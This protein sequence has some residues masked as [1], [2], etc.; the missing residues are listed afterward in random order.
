MT[1]WTGSPPTNV[2][3]VNPDCGS[4]SPG[5]WRHSMAALSVILINTNCINIHELAAAATFIRIDSAHSH[6]QPLQF[7][8]KRKWV[9]SKCYEYLF[10]YAKQHHVTKLSTR[11][12]LSPNQW[13][14]IP[15]P[16]YMCARLSWSHSAFE[17][18]LN[19]SI[20]S[21][22]T[23]AEAVASTV[24]ISDKECYNWPI[25]VVSC[26]PVPTVQRADSQ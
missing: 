7:S 23:T 8:T 24:I 15:F 19:S 9:G 4:T 14:T 13:F 18:T 17:S 20:V 5:Q 22:C 3:I 25:L 12:H 2:I 6:C 21:Y 11:K 10:I 26:C 16:F 1:A